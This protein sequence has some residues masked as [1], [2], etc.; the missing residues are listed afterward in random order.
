MYTINI[1]RA[2]FPVKLGWFDKERSYPQIVDVDVCLEL[3]DKVPCPPRELSETID[4]MQIMALMRKVC[5]ETEW[6]LLEHM[7]TDLAGAILDSSEL[8]QNVSV[9]TWKNVSTDVRGISVE[10]KLTR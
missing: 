8:I 2:R 7:C 5:A 9:R 6:K 1:E 10:A 4:Y 3:S